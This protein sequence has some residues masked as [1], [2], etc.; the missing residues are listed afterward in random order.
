[1]DSRAGGKTVLLHSVA[2][3][4]RTPSV[5]VA[6]GVVLGNPA[7][8]VPAAILDVMPSARGRGVLWDRAGEVR[9]M[10]GC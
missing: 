4:Q 2:G 5:A 3:H 8:E 9:A 10:F 6:Y 1:M 7:E